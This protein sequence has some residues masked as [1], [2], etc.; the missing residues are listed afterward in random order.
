MGSGLFSPRNGKGNHTPER[1]KKSQPDTPI[2]MPL[3]LKRVALSKFAGL[4]L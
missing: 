4:F 2:N 3:A 1:F